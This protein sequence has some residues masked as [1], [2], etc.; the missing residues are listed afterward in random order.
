MANANDC[1]STMPSHSLGLPEINLIS[2]PHQTYFNLF[3]QKNL[4]GGKWA[5]TTTND[6]SYLTHE[7]PS[8]VQSS[9]SKVHGGEGQD[10]EF[11]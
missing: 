10:N 9:D 8:S 5:T 1:E 11:Q 3:N 2:N 4:P 6:L 7:A